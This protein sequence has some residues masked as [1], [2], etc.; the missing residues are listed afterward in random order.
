MK[1][2][3]QDNL[4]FMQWVKRYWD[5]NFPGG[6]YDAGQR[7]KGTGASKS[8]ATRAVGTMSRKPAAS[9]TGKRAQK[10]KGAFNKTFKKNFYIRVCSS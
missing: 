9:S 4:E 10:K 1:C 6:A 3:F 7:R 2:K 8:P 5:Q